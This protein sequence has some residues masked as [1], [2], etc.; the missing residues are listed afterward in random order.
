MGNVAVYDME[1][2]DGDITDLGGALN[3]LVLESHMSVALANMRSV[4]IIHRDIK[5][6]NI[7]FKREPDG[8]IGYALGDFGL[9]VGEMNR[10][11]IW[12]GTIHYMSP[13]DLKGRETGA[14]SGSYEGDDFALGATLIEAWAI[15][16]G[17]EN[18]L[19]ILFPD[20]LKNT[21]YG[22]DPDASS[23]E[24]M[25]RAYA[26]LRYARATIAKIVSWL[27]GTPA[28]GKLSMLNAM[29][30]RVKAAVKKHYGAGFPM[31][32]RR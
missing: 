2:F 18:P 30:P 20:E 11:S 5:P 3:P 23:N 16:V 29:D 27:N 19:T 13:A 14:G 6:D 24:D 25:N 9:A 17:V 10:N 22:T 28:K 4:G 1:R 8:T 12:A 7:Y 21:W 26:Q 31:R 32:S 15:S